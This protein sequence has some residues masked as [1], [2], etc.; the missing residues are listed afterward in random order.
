MRQGPSGFA[1]IVAAYVVTLDVTPGRTEDADTAARLEHSFERRRGEI[2]EELSRRAQRVFGP[3]F[4]VDVRPG[5]PVASIRSLVL[6][7]VYYP[8][9]AGTATVGAL[10]SFA[11]DIEDTIAAA[12]NADGAQPQATVTVELDEASIQVP[13]ASTDSGWERMTPLLGAIATGIGVLGFVTLVGGAIAWARFN[14][15]GLSAED[16]VGFLPTQN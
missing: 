12:V 16:A 15:A 2:A 3:A 7:G 8:V 4:G 6:A 9:K 10:R 5:R 1:E 14:G 11:Y 13:D